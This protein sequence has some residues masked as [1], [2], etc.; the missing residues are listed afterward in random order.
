VYIGKGNITSSAEFNFYQD[1]EAANA[2][3][4]E[5]Q[6][7][8]SMIPWELCVEYA[9]PWVGNNTFDVIIIIY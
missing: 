7:R 3:L 1:P 4:S 9:L 5:L 6:C 2:V 8:I